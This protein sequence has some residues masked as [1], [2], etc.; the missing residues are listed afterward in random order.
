MKMKNIFMLWTSLFLI[1]LLLT[2][3]SRLEFF[4][5]GLVITFLISMIFATDE[6]TNFKPKSLSKSLLYTFIY[7]FI[8]SKECILSSLE[9]AWMVLHPKMP[10]MPGIIKI[11]SS[12]KG[13]LELTVLSNSITLTPGTL[14]IDVDEDSNLYVH[15]IL[16][17]EENMDAA[18]KEISEVYEKYLRRIFE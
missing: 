12:L 6:D 17:K 16:M 9:V 11:P 10:I 3:E 4:V 15:W 13:E 8:L 18:R 1:W 14:L 2:F 7:A 5:S